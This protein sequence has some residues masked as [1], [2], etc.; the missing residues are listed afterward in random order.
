ML[1]GGYLLISAVCA[2]IVYSACVM[3]KRAAERFDHTLDVPQA[4]Q[5]P[6]VAPMHSPIRPDARLINRL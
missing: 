6:T 5:E 4:Q 2:V 1:I 3:A